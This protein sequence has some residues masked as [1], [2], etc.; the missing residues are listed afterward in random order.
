MDG[1]NAWEWVFC[2]LTSVLHV[3]RRNRSA[4]V[5]RDILGEVQAEV[6]VSDCHT[7]RMKVPAKQHQLCMA[8]KLHNLQAVVDLH[9]RLEWP[10]ALPAL[11]QRAIRIHH[12]RNQLTAENFS[13]QAARVERT[14]YRLLHQ[15]VRLV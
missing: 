6:W 11:F 10:K 14:Y 2:T 1:A 5:I 3:I 4:E 8:H 13:Q 15:E 12:Q 7:G 9:P